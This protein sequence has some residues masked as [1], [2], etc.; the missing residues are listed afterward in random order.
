MNTLF[1]VLANDERIIVLSDVG[2]QFI[3]TWNQSDTLQCWHNK[4]GM[5]HE[6][7]ILTQSGYG[8]KTYKQARKIALMWHNGSLKE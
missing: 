8:P 7:D 5:W 3:I 4:N 1:D 2:E 6:Y